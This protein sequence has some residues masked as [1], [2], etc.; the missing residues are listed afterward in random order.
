MTLT[1]EHRG[2][3]A[4][5]AWRLDPGHSSA[6]FRVRTL[7][8]LTSVR[9]RFGDLGGSLAADGKVDLWI[10]A[11]SLRTGNPLRDR[12]LRSADFFDVDRH[13]RVTFHADRLE[14]RPDSAWSLEGELNA[15]GHGLRLELAPI[16]E[17][18]TD[19]VEIRVQTTLEQ[20]RLGMTLTRMGIRSPATLEVRAC[21]RPED[22][23]E[24]GALA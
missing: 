8:G 4:G 3:L 23:V 12:H 19:H 6:K 11:A 1:D 24:Q 10:D 17:V 14:C 15:A 16:V 21:L 22:T 2:E 20:H 9:G 7:W 13:P 5:R 18:N